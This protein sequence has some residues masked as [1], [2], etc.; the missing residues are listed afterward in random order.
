MEVELSFSDPVDFRPTAADFL[1]VGSMRFSAPREIYG[2]SFGSLL[3][4]RNILAARLRSSIPQR[5]N[6]QNKSHE[7]GCELARNYERILPMSIEILTSNQQE[8]CQ[9]EP[10]KGTNANALLPLVGRERS[11]M[12]EH[13]RDRSAHV[14][15]FKTLF[16]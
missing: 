6:Q 9:R 5:S 4:L 12:G 11:S 8:K 1:L 14:Y 10:L 7:K 3:N 13:R 2:M 16:P 15:G